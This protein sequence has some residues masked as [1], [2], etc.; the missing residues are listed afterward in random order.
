M[1]SLESR[2]GGTYFAPDGVPFG[3]LPETRENLPLAG[4]IF[5]LTGASR[6]IGAATA[7]ELAKRG[8]WV[9]GPH[10]DPGKNPRAAE[11]V[12]Q[13]AEIGGRMVAPVTDVTR[14]EH[15]VSLL[16]Q[17]KQEFGEIDGI[18][19]NHAGGM[20][21]D[22]MKA[23]PQYHLKVNGT[24]KDELFREAE[25]RGILNAQVVVI[26]VPSLWSTFQHTGIEQ[27]PQYEKV[28]EGKKLGERLLR[29]AT[30]EYNK[31]NNPRGK[32]VKFGSVC[33]HAI[34]DTTTVRLLSR[35]NRE[36]MAAVTQTAKEGKLP[37]IQD[38]AQAIADMAKG[39]FE[40]EEIIFVGASQVR[41][42]GM[43]G[44]LSMYNDQTRY[45]DSLVEFDRTRAFG[46]Y[47]VRE[48]DTK[49]HFSNTSGGLKMSRS[50]SE[51]TALVTFNHTSG[52]FV[53]AFGISIL[54]GHKMV[55]AA[56][57][58]A[59]FN[60]EN[61]F[62]YVLDPRLT[63]IGW[64]I[65]FKVPVVPG[66]RLSIE[67]I[68]PDKVTADRSDVSVQIGGTEVANVPGL[69]FE[70]R[71]AGQPDSMTPDRIIE[72]AAQ[73]LGVAYLHGRDIRDVLPLFG[74]VKG[75]VEFYKEVFPGQRLEMEAV[76]GG[77]TDKQF[78]GDVTFRVDD[79][80]VAKVLR[81]DCRLFPARGLAR[82]IN[83]GRMRLG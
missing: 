52:H 53:P 14:P 73:T 26:D 24:S 41:R 43:P 83:L 33:G 48:K 65:Q 17:I 7:I 68:E 8:A 4:K 13:V 16:D 31:F 61:R 30:R 59:G 19:F 72:A 66:D 49:P 15:R 45:I 58:I 25:L 39:D 20:E 23:D 76:L 51:G 21:Q 75:P 5:L 35:M 79:E 54:P 3:A 69:R 22:R 27:L 46:Y 82:V 32:E 18:I 81:I 29:E 71:E 42:S 11:V 34:G 1:I 62:A 56:A 37:T 64:P 63:G 78:S 2:Q 28:A 77:S 67:V 9:I 74:G 38:M 70:S 55:A 57:D 12:R 44:I 40:D 47:R 6:G 50:G 36:A 60:L 80:V 10:Q